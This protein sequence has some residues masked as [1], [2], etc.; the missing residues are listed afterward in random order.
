MEP[1]FMN[2]ITVIAKNKNTYFIKRLI[3]ELKQRVVVFDPWSDFEFPT[4]G[5]YISR[6]TGVYGSDLDLLILK[7]LPTLSVFNP[8]DVLKLFRSKC[9]QYKWFEDE[10]LPVLPWLS[11]K[12]SD[13][14][15]VEKFFRLYPEVIVKPLIGQGGWGIEALTW[16]SFRTWKKRKGKDQEYLIQPFLQ[17]STEYRYFFIKGAPPF[18]LER[19]SKTGIV[20]NFTRQGEAFVANLSDE[21]HEIMIDLIHKSGAHYGAIDF[22]VKDNRPYVLELNSVP[23]IEQL[24]KVTGRNVIKEL[25]KSFAP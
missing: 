20:A 21:W 8:H 7:S 18:I 3:E 16:D 6:T 12:E 2:E 25:I 22:L 11:L 19:K 14:V 23:G 4:A 13:L 24:E 10:G 5:T 9:S 1:V 15:T 17:N